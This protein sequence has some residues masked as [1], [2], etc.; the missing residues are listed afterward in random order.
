MT[1]IIANNLKQVFNQLQD[2][3]SRAIFTDRLRYFLD[4]DARHLR[5]MLTT[6][7]L[8]SA[9]LP[10]YHVAQGYGIGDF[11]RSASKDAFVLYGAGKSSVL[12]AA[13]LKELGFT[14][15][16]FCDSDPEKVG[17]IREGLPVISR[18]ELLQ[19]HADKDILI[20]SP[21]FASAIRELLLQAGLD[22]A[23]IFLPFQPDTAYFIPEFIT[24]SAEPEVFID[25]GVYD[26]GTIEQF[27]TFCA[28]GG[29]YE[30]IVGF[31]PD[32]ENYKLATSR[33]SDKQIERV[34]IIPKGAWSKDDI[35][36]F[37]GSLLTSSAF[38]EN[39][40]DLGAKKDDGQTLEIPV[41]SIDK[42]LGGSRASF[43]KMDIE[44][45]ELEALKGA[46]DTITRYK[47]RLAI[48]IYHKPE[49][50]L[51]LP[52]YISGLVP[53]YKFYLRHYSIDYCET[54]LYAIL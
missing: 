17:T 39:G 33:L 1:E 47:P 10:N 6:A 29:G 15:L 34:E 49:D 12:V 13:A 30:R 53:A 32:P 4:G 46:K 7:V 25:C 11:M 35:L 38:L 18:D 14:P 45:S 40:I 36:R 31:E 52:L 50:I 26:G 42:V 51:T 41:T 9:Q 21:A 20:S 5:S 48:S 27:V 43:I 19:K 22:T 8:R 2:D 37:Q 44:G 16:C 54:V 28:A 3:E 24:P 23:Q